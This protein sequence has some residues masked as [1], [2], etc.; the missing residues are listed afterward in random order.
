VTLQAQIERDHSFSLMNITCFSVCFVFSLGAEANRC[1]LCT[2][3]HVDG[4]LKH[5]GAG[6]CS[7]ETSGCKMRTILC[8]VPPSSGWAENGL[9]YIC[10]SL[11]VSA[12]S[13]RLKDVLN[14]T[15]LGREL[16]FVARK[17][18][19][20]FQLLFKKML[21]FSALCIKANVMN[22]V[23]AAIQTL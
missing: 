15:F 19:A 14:F 20:H 17:G 4:L 9:C 23:M 18:T 12:A 22:S 5:P 21:C 1:P 6:F 10:A 16:Y 2:S 11:H 13:G 8:D 3:I 7:T